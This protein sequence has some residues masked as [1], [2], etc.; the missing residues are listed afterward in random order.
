[1][2]RFCA[3]CHTLMDTASWT[4]RRACLTL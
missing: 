3:M 2:T 1:L 4:L